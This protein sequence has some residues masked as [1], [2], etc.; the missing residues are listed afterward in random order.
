MPISSSSGLLDG[1]L[2]QHTRGADRRP[3]RDRD[4]VRRRVAEHG[5]GGL[6]LAEAER[7]G[8]GRVGGEQQRVVGPV[9]HVG[10]VARRTTCPQ[11][12]HRHAELDRPEHGEAAGQLG[13]R[14]ARGEPHE[15]G[16]G[17]GR[18][19]AHPCVRDVVERHGLGGH[20]EVEAVPGDELVE[21]VEVG[22]LA[23]VHLD[24][25]AVVVDDE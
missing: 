21:H 4:G 18:V 2:H 8:G 17:D 9:G 23:G 11:L 20:V 12:G 10:L 15:L 6:D 24:D 13:R 5:H 16:P 7:R 1:A 14:H 22:G 25:P 19:D 3:D